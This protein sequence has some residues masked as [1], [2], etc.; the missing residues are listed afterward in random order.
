MESHK[1]LGR[2]TGTSPFGTDPEMW[3]EYAEQL[4]RSAV[5]LWQ[6]MHPARPPRPS[7]TKEDLAFNPHSHA[8]LFVAGVSLE[9]MLKAAALQAQWNAWVARWKVDGTQIAMDDLSK[10]ERWITTHNLVSLARRA[11]LFLEADDEEE[12]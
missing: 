4:R 6:L 12:L 3:H 5:V 1:P 8:L 11:E 9:T 2:G 7:Y 10:V